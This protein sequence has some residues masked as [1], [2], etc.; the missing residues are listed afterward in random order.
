MILGCSSF[1]FATEIQDSQRL[2]GLISALGFEREHKQRPARS[3]RNLTS[4]HF[5]H[6]LMLLADQYHCYCSTLKAIDVVPC[7]GSNDFLESFELA[8]VRYTPIECP[9]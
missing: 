7:P 1:F 6:C 5:N 2:L 9:C 4:S 3:H 8:G